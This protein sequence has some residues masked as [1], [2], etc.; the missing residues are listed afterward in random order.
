MK[1]SLLL[2]F[3]LISFCVF[4]QDDDLLKLVEDST[5]K[6]P[7]EKVY[8]SFKTT[9]LV[10]A[11][12]TETV[13]KNELD[14]RITHRF[15]NLATGGSVHTMWGFD[16]A[17]DIRYSFDYGL[18][19]TITMGFA[20]SK[21]RELLEVYGK[22]RFLTQTTDN[23][24]P[25]SIALYTSS[26]LTPMREE[27]FYRG[28]EPSIE[29]KFIHRISY[30]SQLVIARKFT[31]WLSLEILPAYHH[32]NFIRAEINPK[33]NKE[34]TNGLFTCGI[35][36]RLKITKSIAIIADYYYI[37]SEFRMNNPL[38]YY[39]PFAVGIEVETGGHVFH[40]NVCN[41]RAISENG[42]IPS[43]QDTWTKGQYK[44]GFNIS[45]VFSF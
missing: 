41:N 12:T 35:G 33:N 26:G 22:Y 45:R 36:G 31:N 34:E 32:R 1:K 6:A 21:D 44:L 23:K 11:Q 43:T 2:V 37:F 28:V 3:N 5:Y 8:A 18:T 40:L 42:I 20:R 16:D 4:S 19:N 29:K 38:G 10:N 14:F 25:V 17:Q 39:N 30:F 9:K 7:S 13:A 15:G 27:A 24:V